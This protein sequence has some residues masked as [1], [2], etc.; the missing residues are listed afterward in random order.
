[1]LRIL[2]IGWLATLTWSG[3]ARPD[4]IYFVDGGQAQ[5]PA[6]IAGGSVRLDTPDG[7]K[8]FPRGDFLAIV[9]GDSPE[10]EW[11]ARREAASRDGGAPARFAASWWALENGLTPEAIAF[12]R[13]GRS[14]VEA[15]EPTRR[16]LAMIDALAPPC[17]DPDLDPLRQALRPSRF[18]EI[19]GDHV[20]LLHQAKE[21]E[22]RDRLDFLERVVSTFYLTFASQGIAPRPPRRR[23]VSVWFAE[24]VD[25][26]AFLRRSDAAAFADAQG[27][28]HPGFDAVFA[29]DARGSEAHRSALRAIANRRRDG[30]PESDLAR[31]E[32]LL[33][34]DRR[35]GDLGIAAHETVHQL[36]VAGGLAPRLDDFP[37]WLHEGLAAQFEVV[38]GGRWA[39][40]GRAH[41]VRLPDWRSIR[42]APRLDPLLLDNGF[43]QGYRREPYAEAWALVYFLRKTKPTE[44]RTFL[45]L[46]R[47]PTPGAS[48]RPGRSI[49]A[50]RSAFG[51]DIPALEIAWHRYLDGIRTPLE[52]GR[53]PLGGPTVPPPE[54]RLA[55][56][57]PA[58]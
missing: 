39:G 19:R 44:F 30:A 31:R 53:P 3:T 58:H 28:Y 32:L 34:L 46:L 13:E 9:P 57:D 27:H 29:F 48:D 12:L 51:D 8:H 35:A 11:P 37:A 23:L 43:G 38:R 18:R 5:L 25:Q 16:A 47:A 15:H 1:M 17:P 6:T 50:F 33:D 24:R 56:P 54:R 26:A 42:P 40:F 41:D 20:V 45:D 21:P 7:P 52:A 10:A 4:L 49:D 55:R 22:A 2:T 14:A 36:T